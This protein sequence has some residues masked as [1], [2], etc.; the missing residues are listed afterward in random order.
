MTNKLFNLIISII[1]SYTCSCQIYMPIKFDTLIEKGELIIESKADIISSGIDNRFL[2][3]LLFGGTISNS[4]LDKNFADNIHKTDQ[5]L[6]EANVEIEHRNYEIFKNKNWGL[7]FKIGNYFSLSSIYTTDFMG[8]VMKGTSYYLNRQIDLSPT[9]INE[10][11]FQ[12]VGIG[13]VNKKNK[14]SIVLTF[15]SI[16]NHF[17][18][19]INEGT[20]NLDEKG[21]NVMLENF[22]GEL[23]NFKRHNQNNYGIGIEFDLK[24]PIT[25]FFDKTIYLQLMSKN[26]GLSLIKRNV[27][28]YEVDTNIEY[29]GFPIASI[30]SLGH[31]F[32]STEKLFD[33]LSIH[34]SKSMRWISMPGFLQAGKIN[35]ESST[36]KL[37]TYYGC[38]I[39]PTLG[40][41]PM[42][43][44]G[45]QYRL[46]KNVRLGISENYGI[47][48]QFRTGFFI[49]LSTKHLNVALSSENIINNF[50]ING[51]GQSYQ[52]RCSWN[53]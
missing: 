44:S 7:S 29:S 41:L 53:Y 22:K 15:F 25:N 51:K 40:F 16:Q 6:L 14:N 21:N 46:N 11:I 4:D 5:L 9:L 33:T 27:N 12:K 52:L 30:Q 32:S 17:N 10:N 42:L 35:L 13:V 45:V 36:S 1:T 37:Q 23:T 48:N 39:Y 26:F 43:F 19:N 50:R 34:H 3:N 2:H 24:I 28:T 8:L 49:K 20:I 47:S 38:R 31:N 18:L